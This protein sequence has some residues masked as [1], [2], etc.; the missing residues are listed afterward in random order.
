MM[1]NQTGKR[2]ENEMKATV[3]VYVYYICI[4]IGI[5]SG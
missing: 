4:C 1:E 5:I 2:V 3:Y